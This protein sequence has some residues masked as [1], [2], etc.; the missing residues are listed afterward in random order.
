MYREGYLQDAAGS[1]IQVSEMFWRKIF[2]FWFALSSDHHTRHLV[3]KTLG[4]Y[5]VTHHK[6]SRSILPKK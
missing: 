1:W 4:N 3:N 2:L 5:R 6:D